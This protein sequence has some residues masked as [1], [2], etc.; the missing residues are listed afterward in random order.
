MPMEG[1]VNLTDPECKLHLILQYARETK[2]DE[3]A[4][5]SHVYFGRWVG[6][7]ATT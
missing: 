2:P 5:P 6:H 7:I 1:D 4:D 3:E